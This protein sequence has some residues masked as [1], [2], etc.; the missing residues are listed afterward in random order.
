MSSIN[1]DQPTG[2]LRDFIVEFSIMG[3]GTM[4]IQAHSIE[5][6]RDIIMDK[7]DEELVEASNFKDGFALEEIIDCGE[8][9]EEDENFQ[10]AMDVQSDDDDND[11]ILG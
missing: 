4:I 11:Y 1:D 9:S 10:D 2:Q 7:S 3:G 5:E 8:E 6:A